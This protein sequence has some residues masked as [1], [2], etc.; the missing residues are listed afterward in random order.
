MANTTLTTDLSA[1]HDAIVAGIKAQFPTLGT[2]E[3]YRT[4]RKTITLPA[5]IL[6]L[7][8]MP[9]APDENPG[10]GQQAI[11]ARFCAH[12]VMGFRAANVRL[13]IRLLAAALAAFLYEKR[14]DGI[15]SGPAQFHGSFE[16]DF[17]PEL[18]QFECWRVDWSHTIWLGT[19]VWNEDGAIRPTTVLYS[20][21]PDIGLPNKDKYIEL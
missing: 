18:D 6:E 8:E 2:V 17:M 7:D 12:L 19:D 16:D 3:F 4:D 21:S 10:N 1:M 13:E 14:W 11:E 15:T 9:P 5:C 20:W